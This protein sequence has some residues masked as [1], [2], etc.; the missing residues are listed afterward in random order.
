MSTP[1]TCH[2]YNLNTNRYVVYCVRDTESAGAENVV[3]ETSE[4]SLRAPDSPTK[5]ITY[6]E[7]PDGIEY[8]SSKKSIEYEH[9]VRI[10]GITLM[11]VFLLIF[12]FMFVNGTNHIRKQKK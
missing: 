3:S 4:E 12:L 8:E 9:I 11:G 7:L 10:F 1:I 2:P 6:N 5:P